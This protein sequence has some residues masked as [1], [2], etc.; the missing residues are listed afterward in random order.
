MRAGVLLS[1][2]APLLVVGAA[3]ARATDPLTRH[4]LP[5]V[6][7]VSSVYPDLAGGRR[8]V[9]AT[10][11][12]AANAGNDC[13]AIRNLGTPRRALWASYYTADGKDPYFQGGESVTPFVYRFRDERQA[14]VVMSRLGN[15]FERCAGPH[16]A[17]DG[18]RTRLTELP[19]G[20]LS[21]RTLAYQVRFRHPTG[22]GTSVPR[23]ELHVIARDGTTVV[24]V[25]LQAKRFVPDLD[26]AVAVARLALESAS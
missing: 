15:Y 10:D 13:V 20:E 2:L 24:D 12:F 5:S 1:L 17:E 25:M 21:D 8:D 22:T 11:T 9:L 14:R 7:A 4:D 6:A 18:T 3:D 26:H 16:R 23:S 19:V